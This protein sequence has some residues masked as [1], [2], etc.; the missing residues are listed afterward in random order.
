MQLLNP[1]LL[2]YKKPRVAWRLVDQQQQELAFRLS[3]PLPPGR[4]RRQLRLP[5]A[6]EVSWPWPGAVA[7]ASRLDEQ[8]A[9]RDFVV[10]TRQ[11]V[12]ML[13]EKRILTIML[14]LVAKMVEV[15]CGVCNPILK[16]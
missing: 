5:L 13:P 2:R 6:L 9:I 11:R 7:L 3:H 4:L 12:G 16:A 14:R 15:I 10:S 1:W 8:R